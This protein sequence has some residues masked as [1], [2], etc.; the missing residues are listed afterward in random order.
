MQRLTG[1]F[2]TSSEIGHLKKLGTVT[3]RSPFFTIFASAV[4]G[5]ICVE[6]SERERDGI[7][8]MKGEREMG[9]FE[10]GPGQRSDVGMFAFLIMFGRWS[11]CVG[12]LSLIIM[13]T[14]ILIPVQLFQSC[15]C[16]RRKK[17]KI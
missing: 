4:K 14:G 10:G 3:M 11:M 12:N 2:M 17:K 1:D 15:F 13:M 6:I 7:L 5:R 8:G 16:F 9:C